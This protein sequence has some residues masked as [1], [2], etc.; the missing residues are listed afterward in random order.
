MS[1]EQDTFKLTEKIALCYTA[2]GPTFRASAI[3]KITENYYDHPNLY[4]FVITDNKEAFKDVKRQNLFVN[5]LKDFYTQFPEIKDY[6]YIL[7]CNDD[8]QEYGKRFMETGYRFSFPAMRFHLLQAMEHNLLNVAIMCTDTYLQFK[9]F[10][11]DYFL[12]KRNVLFNAMSKWPKTHTAY[13]PEPVEQL[14]RRE[15]NL[16]TKEN[17]MVM[18]EAA[19][20]YIFEDKNALLDLFDVWDHVI[21][22]LF[23]EGSMHKY[24]MGG[25][26]FHDETILGAVYSA[27]GFG[28]GDLCESAHW[29]WNVTHNA[30][31]ER[32]WNA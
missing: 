9:W 14:I 7:E 28:E 6:E 26:V 8:P 30:K 4:F 24:Y 1:T 17:Y 32:F 11:D 18:D 13:T 3:K 5:E 21:T 27:I 22:T 31:V 2:C 25:Y 19:R 29:T 23:K 10:T 16:S 20:L 12:K 15:Y